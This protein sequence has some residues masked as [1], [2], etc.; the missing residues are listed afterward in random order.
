MVENEARRERWGN[1]VKGFFVMDKE[2]LG[3]KRKGVRRRAC[4]GLVEQKR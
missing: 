4:G 2:F 1:K 3:E